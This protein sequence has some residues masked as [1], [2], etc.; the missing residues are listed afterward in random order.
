M[1][2]NQAFR[3]GRLAWGIQFHIETTPEIVRAWAAE[4]APLLA[5]FDLDT[6][7]RRAVAVHDD[8]AEVW[9]PFVERFAAIALDPGPPCRR[10]PGRPRPAG[11]ADDASALG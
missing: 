4:D 2:E 9:A 7:V 10:G 11:D 5:D 6:I 1:C 3:L 8:I